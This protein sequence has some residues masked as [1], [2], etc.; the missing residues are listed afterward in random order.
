MAVWTLV[1]QGVV[2]AGTFAFNIALARMVSLT[3]YGHY[4]LFI[5][6]LAL[7]QGV[8]GSL[9]FYPL[10]VRAAVL[11]EDGARA[12]IAT[13]GRITATICLPL[14]LGLGWLVHTLIDPRLLW[15]TVAVLLASQ[16]QEAAR[17]GLLARFRHRD[18]ILGDATSYL[19][20]AALVVGLSAMFAL[21]LAMALY[22]MAATSLLGCAVQRFQLGRCRAPRPPV[23]ATATDFWSLGRWSI[24]STLLGLVRVQS[25]PWAL[26]AL[27]GPAAAGALQIAL[28]LGNVV[29]PVLT[30]IANIIP[31]AASRAHRGG[32][33]A[34]L[35]ACA[36]FMIA[37]A[38]LIAG[39]A[40]VMLAM[41][42]TLLQ[43]VYGMPTPVS[44]LV[45][46]VRWMGSAA[47]FSY[48]GVVGVAYLHGTNEGHGALVV[49][50]GAT[51][52]ALVILIPLIS[53]FGLIGACAT[54]ALG[55]GARAIAIG[56]LVAMRT[57]P[58][59]SVPS[60]TPAVS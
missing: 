57:L 53:W 46:A 58:A 4:A 2:S 44:E 13:A 17:R 5:G 56:A 48:L 54:F 31:Q 51:V 33:R 18:A 14:A 29:N 16:A 15:P 47:I 55:A 27:A 1:D 26:A 8:A 45:G 42:T 43:I 12:L 10:S 30:G 11:D 23:L 21:D 32:A 28:N 52:L 35:T 41:P 36:P 24:S 9:V 19:G 25:L 6:I 49:D 50:I 37:G 20:Q 60:Q 7:M 59:P 34:A 40:L 3:E 39:M 38:P 22:A